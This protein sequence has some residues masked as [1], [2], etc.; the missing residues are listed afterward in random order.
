MR[1]RR[2]KATGT[3]TDES[4]TSLSINLGESGEDTRPA[5]R[6]WVGKRLWLRFTNLLGVWWDQWLETMPRDDD[7]PKGLPRWLHGLRGRLIMGATTIVVLV[8]WLIVI[9]L[10]VT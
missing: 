3:E 1:D 5:K 10:V 4:T 9:V 2:S 8:G 6:P 7:A